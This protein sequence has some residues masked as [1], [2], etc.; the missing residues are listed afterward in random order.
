M[1]KEMKARIVHKHDIEANWDKAVNFIPMQGE[2]IVYDIDENYNY[3]RIKIGDGQTVVANLPF[4]VSA[5]VDIPNFNMYY[6]ATEDPDYPLIADAEADNTLAMQNL[7][8]KIHDNGGG[9]IWLPIGVY[10][11]DRNSADRI[12]VNDEFQMCVEPMSN[13]SIMGESLTETVIRVYG[14]NSDTAWLANQVDKNST[15]VAL[16]GFTYQNFTVDMSA[17]SLAVDTNGQFIY[18]SAAKA[19]G[20]KALKNCVFRDLRILHSPAT[21]LGIDMLDNVVIDS[22]YLYKC[23]KRLIFCTF[24]CIIFIVTTL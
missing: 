23:G 22:I 4:T 24:T 17:S 15:E 3:E 20:M 19:F 1:E 13:V 14:T 9:I 11:F 12:R 8:R 16:S 21:G 18:S 2:I 10:G 6:I 7:M 5:S